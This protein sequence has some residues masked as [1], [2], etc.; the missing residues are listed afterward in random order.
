M[1]HILLL[2]SSGLDSYLAYKKLSKREDITLNRIYLNLN[3]IYSNIEEEFLFKR[4][5]MDVAY[6]KMLNVQYIE[7]PDAYVPNRNLMMV[8]A[9]SAIF[10]HV[11]EIYI[12]GMKDDRVSDNNRELFE[13]YSD[14]LSKSIGKQVKIK[15]LFWDI[16]K[17]DAVK[18][19]ID[20][21]GQIIDLVNDTYSCFSHVYNERIFDVYNK[22]DGEFKYC[23]PLTVTGCLR[24]KACFRKICALTEGNL[25]IPFINKELAREYINN[26]DRTL[27]PTRFKT[28]K[29]Y[30][31][32]LEYYER[33]RKK[34]IAI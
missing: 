23:V 6:T 25:Y 3:S 29:N 30:L 8:T 34:D 28:I 32:F 12:N 5:K 16:E 26:V 20:N 15:S 33:E 13:G 17:G 22:R 1:K 19:Y 2:F 18:N 11:D 10:P 4:Y 7:R 24:C 9:A 21:G 31:K 27:H 14:T